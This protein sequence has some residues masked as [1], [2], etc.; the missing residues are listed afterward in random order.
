MSQ[1]CYV[2]LLRRTSSAQVAIVR[3]SSEHVPAFDDWRRTRAVRLSSLS[4]SFRSN[5]LVVDWGCFY[6]RGCRSWRA[7]AEREGDL[8]SASCMHAYRALLWYTHRRC[9]FS[10]AKCCR[11]NCCRDICFCVVFWVRSG[12]PDEDLDDD[13]VAKL[14][15]VSCIIILFI[16]QLVIY[17]FMYK[18]MGSICYV[19]NWH[20]FGMG[21]LRYCVCVCVC[22]CVLVIRL[23]SEFQQRLAFVSM[24]F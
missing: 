17:L 16:T 7:D 14:V 21:F 4:R 6:L 3:A 9:D 5:R 13:S 1:F 10:R 18:Q 24:C 8:A 2:F 12:V 11:H 19:R 23:T 15:R 22:V 20:G